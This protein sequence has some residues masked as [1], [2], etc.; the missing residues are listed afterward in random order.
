MIRLLTLVL[1]LTVVLVPPGTA[2]DKDT[3]HWSRFRGPNG[4]G[5]IEASGLPTSFAPEKNVVWK[6]SLPPGH[7][8]PVLWGDRL[9]VTAFEE[10]SLLT[11]CLDR[12]TGKELWR[13]PAPR[14]R[15]TKMDQRNNVASPSPAVDNE[16]VTVFF[17][18]YGVIT[19]DRDGK[20]LWRHPLGPFNNL[21][22]MGASPILV[23]RRVVLPCDQQSSSFAIAFD[24][25]TG[26]V[27]WRQE[28]PWAKS[29]HCTPVLHRTETG[30]QQ[31]ILPGSFFL[32]AY[33]AETGARTWF[34]GGLCF[35]MKSVPVLHEGI[36][37]I[38]GFGSPFNQ[39]GKQL[40]VGS[41]EEQDRNGDGKILPDEMP[42]GPLKGW[43]DFVDLQGDGLLDGGDWSYLRAALASQNGLLAIRAGGEGDRTEQ[44]VL[45]TYRRGIPQLPSPLL[46]QGVLYLVNDSG[47]LAVT[48][49]PK[50]GEVIER[51]RLSAQDNYYAS[52]V[53]ADD[54]VF[55]VSESGLVSVLPAGGSLKALAVNE[56]GESCY[57]TP[58]IADGRLYLR[59]TGTLYCFGAEDRGG[60]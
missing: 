24:K 14:A 9:F 56:L 15:V 6:V 43:F 2:A 40:T 30:L 11:L 42:D 20:E 3:D 4:L 48:L 35:E 23:G 57:A 16:V 27:L 31:L 53:A 33:D 45:W 10:E 28:R 50:T 13:R 26:E 5:V 55:L 58:A 22:G 46:F 18:D 37:Y 54:K 7:S 51:G 29:G 25:K 47:G 59:T 52:P 41:F 19:Y 44:N 12:N 17:Q 36:I 39:P 34:V 60:D 1:T 38:N 21:Y 49:N 8:S 32:D